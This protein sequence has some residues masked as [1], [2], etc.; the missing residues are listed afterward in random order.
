MMMGPEGAAARSAAAVER[1][2]EAWLRSVRR[3]TLF[4]QYSKSPAGIKWPDGWAK[5]PQV[6]RFITC[7]AVAWSLLGA[8]CTG[9]CR[10]ACLTVR[11]SRRRYA[12]AFGACAIVRSSG[13]RAVS[14]KAATN[15]AL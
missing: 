13:G 15:F 7:G 8:V 12:R 6:M 2:A 9:S 3:R 1:H 14:L 4:M 10:A 5:P 11:R